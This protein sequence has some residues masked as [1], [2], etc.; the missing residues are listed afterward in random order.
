MCV[1]VTVPKFSHISNGKWLIQI[2]AKVVRTVEAKNSAE[3]FDLFT[4]ASLLT[5]G[6]RIQTELLIICQ[7]ILQYVSSGESKVNMSH[8][9]TENITY[10]ST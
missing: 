10:C 6:S 9:E 1:I 7:V 4:T 8:E 2:L 3:E 5:I